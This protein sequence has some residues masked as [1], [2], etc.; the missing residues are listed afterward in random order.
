MRPSLIA[1]ALV[2]ST[3]LAA[4]A[5]T[6]DT[7]TL[8]ARVQTSTG[9][10]LFDGTVT[11]DTTT[12]SFSDA[13]FSG[14]YSGFVLVTFSGAPMQSAPIPGSVTQVLFTDP[15]LTFFQFQINDSE[16]P[17]GGP[18]CTSICGDALMTTGYPSYFSF[19]GGP[20]FP[21]TGGTLTFENTVV[22]PPAAISPEPSSIILL[23]TGILGLVGVA[24]R[25]YAQA[26]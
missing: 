4:H 16:L 25:R 2:L 12:K 10:S 26:L 19:S 5:D 23:G 17:D 13:D 3:N 8:D 1:V 7:F 14:L 21:V 20:D 6:L 18:L 9:I 22:T 24:R 11:Y 15:D